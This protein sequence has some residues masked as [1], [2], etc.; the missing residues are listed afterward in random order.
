[1]VS[2]TRFYRI[3][4]GVALLVFPVLATG[5]LFTDPVFP[6]DGGE[7]TPPTLEEPP[8]P[9]N[10]TTVTLQLNTTPVGFSVIGSDA[11]TTNRLELYYEWE[12]DTIGTPAKGLDERRYQT[13][14]Q[15]LGAGEHTLRVIV[16]DPQ[17]AT[18]S[19]TWDILVQ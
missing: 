12:L 19:V 14:G 4:C 5:C 10:E 17:G 8:S 11:E 3:A 2:A 7:N 18:D 15:Q 13:S 6:I 16:F 1:M 9:S